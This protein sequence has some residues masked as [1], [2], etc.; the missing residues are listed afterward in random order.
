MALEQRRIWVDG[1]LV[2]W[3][4][5]TVHVLS[6]SL[7][8]GTLVF[9]YMRV[10][11]T[12]KGPAIFRLGPHLDRFLLSSEL[13]GLPLQ[14]GTAELAEATRR[15]VRANPGSH[16][17]KISAYLA[18]IEVEVVPQDDHVSVAIAAYDVIEDIVGPNR[19]S[20]LQRDL[21]KLWIEKEKRNR[22]HDILAPQA[23][24]ASN[25]GGTMLAK[26]RARRNGYDEILLLS[27]DGSLAESPTA[28]LFLVDADGRLLTPQAEQV[29]PGVTRA[30]I[31]EIAA[32]EGIECCE[33]RLFP[34]DL[35][36]ASEVFLSA[37]S[38]G[39]WPVI[40]VDGRSVGSGEPGPVTARLRERFERVVR[41]EDPTF[42][43]W[44]DFVAE[45]STTGEY[46]ARS[47]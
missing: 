38:V 39:V 17:V 32:A 10:Y 3:T 9:D 41:G 26:W 11:E 15:T 33:K 43:H 25:Y 6:H 12:T 19:G 14:R 29:L 47:A 22:R 2:A 42:E 27:E 44:L 20:H 23:K 40:S 34:E 18:S 37:T 46:D 16:S 1:E 35:M 21:L 8:R 28:N 5:A 31:L 4:D 45:A 30:S 24:V 7:Q 13:L 36:A